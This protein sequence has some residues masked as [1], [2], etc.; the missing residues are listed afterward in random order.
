MRVR[1]WA[2]VALALAGCGGG[3][4]EG[5]AADAGVG[6]E[7]A[8]GSGGG[9]EA[10]GRSGSGGEAAGRKWGACTEEADIQADG[11]FDGTVDKR[12][13]YT[14]DANGNLLTEGVGRRRRRHG[15]PAR[16]LHLRRDR[17]PADRGVGRRR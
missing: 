13:T 3:G 6:G 16:D 7:A 2:F 8:G 14:Y 17:A 11:R 5:S 9:G 10:A 1:H 12:T 15:E 4:G